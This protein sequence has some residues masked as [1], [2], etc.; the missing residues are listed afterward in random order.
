MCCS[1]KT[2]L[3]LVVRGADSGLRL[4]D[5][6]ADE[7]RRL[8][9]W[10]L[11]ETRVEVW[12]WQAGLM[13]ATRWRPKNLDREHRTGVGSWTS[14]GLSSKTLPPHFQQVNK[15][16]KSNNSKLKWQRTMTMPRLTFCLKIRIPIYT[17]Q[18]IEVINFILFIF[19]NYLWIIANVLIYMSVRTISLLSKQYCSAKV[20][21]I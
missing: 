4:A 11:F 16:T 18:L 19:V 15:N 8:A 1:K 20:K 10:W 21:F 2:S 6:E 7:W 9:V 12:R 17:V 14:G 13:L 3:W 5:T